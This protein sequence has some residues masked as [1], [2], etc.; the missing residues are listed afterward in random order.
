MRNNRISAD[1]R[2]VA[3]FEAIHNY[4]IG[5]NPDII[6]NSDRPGRYKHYLLFRYQFLIFQI[7]KRMRREKI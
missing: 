7:L 5:T 3:N 2:A 6:A 4:D 1:N